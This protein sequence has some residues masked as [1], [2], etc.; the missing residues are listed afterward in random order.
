[1]LVSLHIRDFVIVDRADIS[2][3]D[4]FTVFTG[5]TGAGKSILIDAL[6]LTLGQ[7]ASS[8][9]VRSGCAKADISS[10]FTVSDNVGHW[11]K[12][13]DYGTDELILR[14]VIDS[15]SNSKAFINGVPC[16]LAQM[17]EIAELVIDIH[18]QHAHQLLL[19]SQSQ[20]DL[21]DAQGGHFSLVREVAD[22][23]N[24]L[25][26]AKKL[27]DEA[28]SKA[29]SIDREIAQVQWEL[30]ELQELQPVEGEWVLINEEH[31]RL[32][33][34]SELIDGVAQIINLLEAEND[35]A[36]S[37]YG[38]GVGVGVV[39]GL[40]QSVS[41]L[42]NLVKSDKSLRDI[43][44]SLESARIAAD[45]AHSE[46]RR[47]LDNVENDPAQLESVEARLRK[48][49]DLSK[50]FRFQPEDALEHKQR[51]EARLADLEVS[52]DIDGLEAQV[53]DCES[54]YMSM[55]SKLSEARRA[56]AATLGAEVSKAM[57]TLA[58]EGGRF[59]IATEA[60][61]QANAHGLESIQFLVAGHAGT[62]VRP[63]SKVASGGELA[64]ISL[65]IS[66]IAS[67]AQQVPTLIFDEVDSGIG[68]GVAEIVGKLLRKLSAEHQVLCVTHL[69]QVAACAHHHFEVNKESREN[70]TI[71]TIR[72]LDETQR[73]DEI[74]RMLGGVKITA[75]T[76]AHAKELIETSSES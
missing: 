38:S 52:V 61:P 41:I 21:L 49:Y 55:A 68:G 25:Q 39:D 7:R 51:L 23:W 35:G 37:A 69:P 54:K 5:E 57:Q 40:E 60:L 59:E 13:H 66:V 72:E 44:D 30:S 56:T 4:G 8:S 17:K 45:E 74:A 3:E 34:A 75:T 27:L 31:T 65:A 16:T 71:S 62:E 47:Y 67:R 20:R 64:R 1:M 14:R 11:L 28:K 76:K 24:K 43:L 9:V 12:E 70:G 73:V 19:R 22:A 26:S 46:L 63:L 50:K 29:D 53:Q 2:F 10:V 48:Y 36:V 42:N 15:N 6:L 18:G 32:S 58:M 33:N